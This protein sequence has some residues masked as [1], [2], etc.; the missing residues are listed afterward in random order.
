MVKKSWILPLLLCAFLTFFVTKNFFTHPG[1]WPTH[2][3]EIHLVRS[4]QFFHELERGQFPVRVS[5]DQAYFRS[6][7]VFSFF[8]PLPYY[9]SALFQLAG[10][11]ATFSW[12]LLLLAST[13]FS[14]L[15]FYAWMRSYFDLFAS[16]VAT[17]VY[18][19]V[20]F[21]FLTLF[22]T[23]QIGG[24]LSLLWASVLA[25]GIHT[26]IREKSRVGGIL[27][28]VGG[29]SMM[30]SHAMSIIIFGIPLAIYT[31]IVLWQ[32][33]EKSAPFRLLIGWLVLAL[34]LSSFYFIPFLFE[35]DTVK[36]GH[37][38][39]T[40]YRDHYTTVKQLLYSPWGYYY[41]NPGPDD[42]MSLQVGVTVLL[43]AGVSAILLLLKSV[44][45]QVSQK[46]RVLPA[47]M[48]AVFFL[49]CFL[50]T[51][52]S[53]FIWKVVVPLQYIQFPWRLLAA[54]SF[55]GAWLAGWS[56]QE[57]RGKCRYALA[58]CFI[59]LAV[60]NVRNYT[61]P[62]PLD[63]RVDQD[64]KANTQAYYGPTDIFWELMPA[65]VVDAPSYPPESML[66]YEPAIVDVTRLE[67][68]E[69]GATRYAFS[70]SA[71]QQSVVEF[72]V[73]QYPFWQIMLD[74]VEV[75]P[76]V[77]QQGTMIISIPEGEHQ[78]TAQLVTTPAQKVG[79]LLTV[80][81]AL[82]LLWIGVR[83]TRR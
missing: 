4:M 43:A 48:I 70:L 46:S 83:S 3:G 50:Q 26:T 59:T 25:L 69:V 33:N 67:N 38:L 1:I 42:G 2:D 37:G 39:L 7:P 20:P 77:G 73:W 68:Q 14:L 76:E 51:E 74:G 29:A 24:Y 5:V 9:T 18:A 55:V 28:A 23:G 15:F 17:V 13:F 64:F 40:D 72:L 81:A 71:T 53:S 6:Y 63:W 82:T 75:K 36:M 56:M 34:G 62:W 22:V 10:F 47:G 35:R 12:Q 61:N 11:S 57:V 45:K 80:I 16:S 52:H 8:Y 49:L 79:D 21:Q 58:A 30:L 66:V 31:L 19:L 44:K 60:W 65:G 54:T 41:S 32:E 27:V 78:L